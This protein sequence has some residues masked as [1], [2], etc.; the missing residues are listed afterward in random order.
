MENGFPQ[1]EV[2]TCGNVG[3]THTDTD[4]TFSPNDCKKILR[5]WTVIDWCNFN[6]I[7]FEGQWEYAQILTVL[8]SDM[9]EF[10]TTCE[11]LTFW[12]NHNNCEDGN[13][14]MEVEA[15]DD[16]TPESDLSYSFEIDFHQNGNIDMSGN[17]KFVNDDLPLGNHSVTF[18]V[19]DACGQTNSCEYDFEIL[20]GV[21]PSP[22]CILNLAVELNDSTVTIQAEELNASSFDNCT[23]TSDLVYSFSSDTTNTD[24]TFDCSQVGL[25]PVQLWVTDETG[26][27]ASCT[28]FIN[29]QDNNLIC[30]TAFAQAT[31]LI[32]NEEDQPIENVTIQLNN[33]NLPSV[34]TSVNGSFSFSQIPLGQDYELE[35]IKTVDPTNGVTTF[36]LVL[37]TQHI[38]GTELLDS[39]YKIIAADANLSKTITTFDIVLLRRLIL[40]IDDNFDDGKSWRFVDQ[41]FSFPNIEDP[42]ESDFPETIELDNFNGVL[43]VNFVAIKKGDVNGSANTNLQNSNNAFHRENQL[44]FFIYNQSFSKDEKITIDLFTHDFDAINGFQFEFPFDSN[45]FDFQNLKSNQLENFNEEN[46]HITNDKVMVSWYAPTSFFV[47]KNKPILSLELMTHQDGNIREDLP[48]RFNPFFSEIYQ[49]KNILGLGLSIDE[50][51]KHAFYLGQN[52]PNPFNESTIINFQLPENQIV[53]FTIFDINGKII[54]SENKFYQKGKNQIQFGLEQF[55]N[56]GLYYYQVKTEQNMAIRKMIVVN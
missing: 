43:D 9:P 52:I 23:N 18:S 42:F 50:K 21:E 45:K 51:D 10:T 24:T 37:I 27:Q 40:T 49:E 28:A 55:N 54:F 34:T 5:K 1:V 25:N 22:V 48:I 4:V 38:L 41:N 6:P 15:T 36:D 19:T 47:E 29:L 56:A 44:S 39:P 2:D 7:T 16:C 3:I 53:N 46:Y 13:V 12:S 17:E 8:D 14:H 26:N 11:N 32:L 35:P 33:S 31:G 30:S 20:D